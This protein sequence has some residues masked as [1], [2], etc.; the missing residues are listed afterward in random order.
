MPIP[1][2]CIPADAL[3]YIL[4]TTAA[5]QALIDRVVEVVF[6]SLPMAERSGTPIHCIDARWLHRE[7]PRAHCD[8]AAAQ[9]RPLTPSGTTQQ[10]TS[11][12]VQA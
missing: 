7:L 9:L 2:L 10:H 8:A 3:W 1:S 4:E 6:P 11:E 5:K 12:P